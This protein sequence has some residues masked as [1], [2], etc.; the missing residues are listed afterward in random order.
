MKIGGLSIE[1]SPEE[2]IQLLQ[3][4]VQEQTGL[5]LFRKQKTLA[6]NCQFS[7]PFHSGGMEK[8]P[9]CGMSRDVTYSGSKVVEAGTVHCFTCKYTANLPKF[10][11]DVLESSRGELFGSQWLKRNFLAEENIVRPKLN[12]FGDNDKSATIEYVTE[13]EL[14]TYRYYHPYMEERGLTDD[15]IEI[16]DVGFDEESNCLTFPV[17]DLNGNTLFIYRRGVKN[18]FHKYGEGDDKT[19]VLYGAYEL[20]QYMKQ[21]EEDL[22]C[23]VYITES[24]INCLTL[25]K[26]GYPAISIMGLGGGNQFEL[27]RKLPYR[28]I[29]L[30]LDPDKYGQDAQDVLFEEVSSSKVVMRLV[31]SQEIYE[32]ELD[33]NSGQELI[34]FENIQL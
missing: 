3:S 11:A 10:I 29:V 18:K 15:L 1:A 33:I 27:I 34:D 5:F 14:D 6:E 8:K 25:W 7:C 21:F 19:S 22:Q 30:A 4:E 23:T 31:Y 20:S 24:I 28:R 12:L 16:F 13:E 17:K 9:S 26:L 2:I 32:Q